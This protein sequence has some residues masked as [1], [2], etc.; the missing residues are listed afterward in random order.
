[1]LLLVGIIGCAIW[2]ST[3]VFHPAPGSPS[4]QPGPSAPWTAPASVSGMALNASAA[5]GLLPP[6]GAD[7]SEASL[8]QLY[9]L[10]DSLRERVEKL[11]TQVSKLRQDTGILDPDPENPS[12]FVRPA[13]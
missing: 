7:S 5:S 9:Q 12:A 11:Y 4:R 6:V 2:L 13:S 10:R 8:E 3:S 1:M